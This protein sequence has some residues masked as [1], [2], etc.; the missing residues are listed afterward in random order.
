[1][2]LEFRSEEG[3]R[4]YKKAKHTERIA[5]TY[6]E[7]L[8]YTD[9]VQ[10]M[11]VGPDL[12]AMRYGTAFTFEVKPTRRTGVNSFSVA[13]VSPPRRNDDFVA[14]VLPNERT[15]LFT[16]EEHL[17]ACSISGTRNVRALVTRYA[18]ECLR[19]TLVPARRTA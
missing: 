7:T 8:G 6:L 17:A 1:M 13:A 12:T 5:Q 10:A 18:P 3:M 15:L 4:R 16:M 19:P 14:I 2:C 11:G 9:F